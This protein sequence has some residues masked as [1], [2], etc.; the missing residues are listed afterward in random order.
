MV[1]ID[2]V[3]QKVLAICNKEQRGYIT[4]QEFNLMA[5]KAQLDIYE[6][7][8]HKMKTSYHKPKNQQGVGFDDI[9]MIQAKLQP[10]MV[11]ISNVN[12]EVESDS[13]ILNTNA[14]DNSVYKIN[15]VSIWGTEIVEVSKKELL[16]INSN[17]LTSPTWNRPVYVRETNKRFRVYPLIDGTEYVISY[18]RKPKD[19][20]WSYVVVNQKAL[21]NFNNAVHFELHSSEEEKL[22][23]RI[24]MLAGVLL[25]KPDL[26][27]AASIDSVR[28]AKEQNE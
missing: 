15:T 14:F 6:T 10:F 7:Y 25:E 18:W 16:M 28:T 4:P 23:T 1:N 3:Y 5:N 12:I 11:D 13:T 27:Q 17:P 19:P 8:F 26:T 2:T 22:V 9:E 24:L 21:Y 20:V